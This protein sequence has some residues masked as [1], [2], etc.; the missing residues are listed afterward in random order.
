MPDTKSFAASIAAPAQ[1]AVATGDIP[2]VVCLVWRRGELL[3]I[4]S[5][6]LRDIEARLPVER[7]TVFR[8]ASMSKPVTT[9]V[10]MILR[11]RGVLR[12]EDPITKWAP[13]FAAMRVLRRP[14]GPLQDT[15][16]APRAIT[17]EDLMTHRAG[18][19]YS[20]TAR[21]PMA[22]ALQER[23]GFEFDSARTPDEWTKT[24]ASLPLSYA[25]GE[26]F[27]YSH[28]TDL[29]G[30]IIGRATG[31]GIREAM[32]KLLFDP[33]R[34]VDTDFWIPPEKRDRAAV[35]Y[36][37]SAPGN[38]SAVDLPGFMGQ[39]PP[40]FSAGGQGLVSTADD[41]LAFARMLLQG[42]ELDGTRVLSE[43]SI[44]LMTTNRLTPAQRRTLQFGIPFF[45]GQGFGLGLSVIDDAKRNAWMGAG[46]PGAFGWPGLFGGWWQADPAQQSVMVWLQQTLPPQAIPG[47]GAKGDS[48]IAESLLRWLFSSPRLLSLMNNIAQRS[49]KAPRLPGSAATQNFQRAAYS[50]LKS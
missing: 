33:L 20:F 26:R 30:V 7:S 16:A 42:G 8:I 23:F 43:E 1:H 19:A 9:A 6:G 34:M 46:R 25:P 2:G 11:E 41:Y 35:L 24:L 40:S 5:V 15:Y 4:D 29:L 39:S 49:G 38:F 12:L 18:L 45:M 47:S 48:R 3:Q 50:A 21:G 14:D 27:N 10:A 37:S 17:I 13:E 31:L 28:S 22:R 36:R 44:R 32:Q